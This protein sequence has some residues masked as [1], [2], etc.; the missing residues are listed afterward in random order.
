M[1]QSIWVHQA[2]GLRHRRPRLPALPD[3]YELHDQAVESY[4]NA[5]YEVQRLSNAYTG[6]WHPDGFPGR[7]L[8]EAMTKRGYH[9]TRVIR[10]PVVPA[11]V[12]VSI[13]S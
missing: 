4:L 11:L 6:S 1:R 12:P 13:P 10:G 5:E 2:G 9:L 8:A 7:K 3:R